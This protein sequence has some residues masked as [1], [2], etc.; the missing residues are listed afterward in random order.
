MHYSDSIQGCS[1]SRHHFADRNSH[2]FCKSDI[3]VV[4]L[5]LKVYVEKHLHDRNP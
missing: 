1:Y 4:A 2:V 3:V 5:K